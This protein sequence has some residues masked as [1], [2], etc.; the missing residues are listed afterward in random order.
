M[1]VW[2]LDNNDLTLLL[3]WRVDKDH[4]RIVLSGYFKSLLNNPDDILIDYKCANAIDNYIEL[5][6]LKTINP[7]SMKNPDSNRF[8]I[9]KHECQIFVSDNLKTTLVKIC[10]DDFRFTQ[11]FSH[12]G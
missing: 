10:K 5:H 12:F 11:G 8:N 7:F 3:L 6:I 1:A 4:F 9:R 2:Q